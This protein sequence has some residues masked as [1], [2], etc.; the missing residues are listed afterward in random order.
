MVTV[1]NTGGAPTDGSTVTVA[2]TL[3]AGLSLGAA[4]ISGEDLLSGEPLS[5]AGPSCTYSGAVTPDD[6]LRLTVPVVVGPSAGASVTNTVSVSGGGAPAAS[7]STPT[8]ISST[9]ASF[10]IAPGSVVTALSSTQAGAH[11]DL[12]T[13]L[14]F[15]TSD[16]LNE[17]G[18]YVL[19]DDPR[20]TTDDLPPGFAGDVADA[21]TCSVAD[22]SK[23]AGLFS[24]QTCPLNTQVGT[25][26]LRLDFGYGTF[27]PTIPIYNLTPNPGEVAKL[28]FFAVQFGIQGEISVRPG[29]Y[30]V[31]TTF[32]N[33]D[34]SPAAIDSAALSI[35]GVPA[36]PVHNAMRGL[37]CDGGASCS[38]CNTTECVAATGTG[39]PSTSAAIPYLTNPTECS[40]APLQ[41]KLTTASWQNPDQPVFAESDIGPLTGCN[42]LEFSP[43]ITT[44]LDTFEADAAAGLT[45]EVQ[46][47]QEGL[48][49]P[50]GL[51]TADL[52]NTTVMLPAGL[53]VN[54]GR[55]A[56]LTA[57]QTFEDGVGREGP[58][59]CPGSSQVGEAE[60][61][62][63]LLKEKLKGGVYVLQSNPPDVKLL[64]TAYAPVYGI[65][66]KL[67]G[68]AKLNE[69]TGQ[70]TTTF[71]ETPELPFSHFKLILDGG[72]QPSLVTPSTCG[73]YAT[74]ADFTPWTAPIGKDNPS[75]G[76]FTIASGP[77]GSSCPS[78]PLPFAPVLT[79]GA[80]SDNAGGFTGFSMLLQRGGDQQRVQS[81]QIKTPEGLLGMVSTVPLCREPQAAQG[82]C[83]AASQI[84]H[85]VVTAGPGPF[86]LTVPQPGGPQAPI[87][88]TGGY[89]GAPY[90]LSIA[91]PVIAGPFNL[92]TV[93]VRSKIEIDSHTAQVTIATDPLPRIL[94]GVPT[95]LGTISAVIDRPGFVI[96][97]TNCMQ[98]QVAGTVTGEQPDGT[99]GS[100]VAVSS[101]FAVTGCKGL[102]FKPSFTAS[103]QAK[104]SKAN[105]ASLHV[106]VTSGAG[107]A[108]IGK[109][110]IMLPKQ[111]PARLTTLQK[112]CPDSVFNVNPSA[113]P[114]ASAIGTAIARTPVL[115]NPLTG[116]VYLVSHGGVAF[117]D[118]VIV[119]QGEGITL[120]LD[121]NTNIKK[122]ITSSTFSSVPDAPIAS[123][124]TTLPEGPHS[125]F[126]T[127][128]PAK[129]RGSMCGQSLRIP[130]TLVGQNGS[131]LTQTTK[132]AVTGCPKVKKKA[133]KASSHSHGRGKS[134]KG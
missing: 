58:A 36:D 70:V 5:C 39:Q 101:P 130:T 62:T 90:G 21:P 87:Y 25:T 84:G 118:A 43:W 125:A 49:S 86:P 50:E 51:S 65:Y 79:A 113:C 66:V 80:S 69:T 131:V 3:P 103:T 14:A 98:S 61:T 95:D 73:T 92:G 16:K 54:P 27:T 106:K 46:V 96:N 91:V 6:L 99:P 55:A 114:A 81:L 112:A 33:V 76:E 8:T 126:G 34:E 94:D 20:S 102:P 104:T 107:Q 105:G 123:F 28:G 11:A 24:P 116:P 4:G 134:T 63:P 10:G 119:L 108:N 13:M 115:T 83:P 74:S 132:I 38:Y 48:T 71:S 57:C 82:A 129:A 100:T 35:W 77:G 7:A 23:E 47:P 41:A 31:R 40:G 93:V 120:Y 124:E 72:A 12:T 19:A 44:R 30:G 88:L 110:R 59:S 52:K 109:V 85:T 32:T 67:I 45:T 64:V 117:P 2:D 37:V 133:K 42:L 29:D 17:D 127:D 26:T 1:M 111:L 53:A 97:P 15:N 122:G 9:P 75:S 121:G 89:G 60:V 18:S 128:I 68:D 78:S 56:G 22:F